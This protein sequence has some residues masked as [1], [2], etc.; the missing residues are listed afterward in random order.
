MLSKCAVPNCENKPGKRGKSFH[1]FPSDPLRKE[2]WISAIHNHY[3][4]FNSNNLI[5]YSSVCSDHFLPTNF[6][7]SDLFLRKTLKNEAVPSLFMGMRPQNRWQQRQ[8]IT[9]SKQVDSVAPLIVGAMQVNFSYTLTGYLYIFYIQSSSNLTEQKEHNDPPKKVF[10]LSSLSCTCQERV[11]T[12]E[13]EILKLKSEIL[14][15][16]EKVNEYESECI[17]ASQL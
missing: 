11:K 13:N 9:H 4:S 14:C 7:D 6:M 3:D 8:I 17:F 1:R 5:S 12:L 10:I 2:K 16:K 15:L